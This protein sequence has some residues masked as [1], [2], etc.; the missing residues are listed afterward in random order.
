M[1]TALALAQQVADASPRANMA[2]WCQQFAGLFWEAAKGRPTPNSYA[3]AD[4]ARR[5]SKI[6]STDAA[7]A[8]PGAFHWFKENHVGVALGSGLMADASARALIAIKNLGH[9]ILVH[10]V[11]DYPLTYLGWSYTN[12]NRERIEG[13]TDANA[14]QLA[15]NQRRVKPS[16]NL[17]IRLDRDPNSAKI[18]DLA[19]G[20]IFT[21]TGYRRGA[22]VSGI[23]LWY[24]VRG[25]WAWAGGTTDPTTHN[26]TDLTMPDPV[27]APPA[28]PEEEPMPEP[29]PQPEPQPEPQQ[30][31]TPVV[32]LDD[33][34]LAALLATSQAA[35]PAA[36]VIPDRPAKVLWVVLSLIAVSVGPVV[37]LTVLDWARWDAQIGTQFAT[38]V[39]A[40]VGSVG[41]VLGLSRYAKTR[42]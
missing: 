4:A 29:T 15:A 27:P 19:P 22:A 6:V 39:A 31:A 25:G 13:L 32:A 10:R 24:A 12:G 30:P 38:T 8:P 35:E 28:E 7:A 42:P 3:S 14:P 23:D 16:A 17:R 11:T 20:E 40:W 26:L 9:G 1:T 36:P 33:E 2:G 18:G 37:A 21:P 34:R 41:V 5:A